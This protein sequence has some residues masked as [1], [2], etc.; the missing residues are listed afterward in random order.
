MKGEF[1][2]YFPARKAK[3]NLCSFSPMPKLVA[4]K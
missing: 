4:E 2:K 1:I 3:E